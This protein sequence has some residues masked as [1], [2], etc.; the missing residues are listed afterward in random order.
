MSVR[1]TLLVF[2]AALVAAAAACATAERGPR[3]I[4][5]SPCGRAFVLVDRGRP[6]ATIV[7]PETAGE[8]ERRAAE[9]LRTSILK[10]S[11]VDLPV[12]TA[13]EPGGPAVAAIGFPSEALPPTVAPSLRAMRVDGFVATTST[14]NLYVC[15]GGGRG[16]VYGVVH[17]LEKYFGCRRFSPTAE[18][19]PKRDDIYLGCLLEVDN[20]GS[21]VRVVNGEFALDP[22][23]RDWMRLHDHRDLY[24]SGYYV[25]TFQR[26][27]PWQTYFDAHPEYFAL[28][29]GKRV[30]DQPCLS[31]PEVFDIAVA[32]LREEMAA[33]PERKIWS[34]S[35]NDNSSYC[36]CPE[37]LK[38]IE[39]EGSPSGP[40]IR[41][42]NRLAALFPDKTIST[43][44][45]QYSRPAPRLARPLPN[46]EVMLCT[47]ELNRSLP[48]AEDPSSVSFVR[49]IED[50]SRI[51]GNI[52]LWDYT[53]NFS[54]HVSPFPNLH[55]LG[56]NIRFFFDHGVRKHFQQTNTSPGHEWSELKSYLLARLL[57]DPRTDFEEVMDDFL[58]GYYGPAAPFLR[59]YNDALRE[60][61]ER[62]GARLDI[63]EP[64]AVHAGDYLSAADVALYDKLFDR[65]EA[66][67]AKDPEVLT[68]VR[69]ARLPLLYAELEIGK[70]DMFGPRGFYEE[71]GDRFEARPAMIRRLEEFAARC[72]A[73]GVRTLNESGLTPAAYCDSVKRF[74][75][76]QVEGNMAFRKPV[77]AD[78]PP[79]AKYAR[80]DLAVLTNG[81]RGAS[82]FKVHWLGWEG[83]DFTLT[84]D[85]GKPVT[86][87]EITLSTLS[88]SRSW[89]LHPDKV[90]C[91]VSSDSLTFREIG[92][93]TLAGDHR[94]EDVVRAF[95]WTGDMTAP[96]AL[97]G[98]R[99]VR[100]RVEG[101]KRLPAWHA[102]AGGLSW[103]FVDEIVVR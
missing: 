80:G 43:L 41:F 81:V 17:L 77:V 70:D 11:G 57:W 56:P 12:R 61:I 29:N 6:A 31:R 64:P 92:A 101:T 99:Y 54:H 89:I 15:G 74:I 67:V 20:P 13:S 33:Q 84:V 26:L 95:S 59:R 32:K 50:W 53:V 65:A 25:H 42:V 68:R 63:Y 7:I 94:D 21:D 34:V 83:V 40:I 96:G 82:D 24:G 47:I 60:A 30:I 58:D 103:V 87:R 62:T 5:L 37:C 88:D 19:F 85:L 8:P 71:N 1:K 51:C 45:Y 28:M 48:I 73:G 97:A 76:V 90:A 69:T 2:A 98:V 36:Q 86:A 9:I 44:A 93:K 46:V 72:K 3:P 14:G 100:F 91:E 102:S 75:E 18:V 27:V 66:A 39:E 49:D 16:V 55:V 10:M 38:A 4:Q 79:A 23:Y 35:Q 78:P 52:Y 22:D